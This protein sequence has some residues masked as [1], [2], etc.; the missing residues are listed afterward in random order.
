MDNPSDL[1]RH[2]VQLIE[3]IHAAFVVPVLRLGSVEQVVAAAQPWIDRGSTVLEVP[4]TVP[5][6]GQAVRALRERFGAGV[7][8][9]AG[10]V[11]TLDQL[12]EAA[13]VGCQFAA[14]PAHRPGWVAHC[15][16]LGLLPI[17][18]ALTP[19]EIVAV[20]EAGAPV[21]KIFPVSALG[22]AG[23]L[24]SLRGPFPGVR[25]MPCGGIR[26]EEAD[27]YRAAGAWAIG[28]GRQAIAG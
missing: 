13:A 27:R 5:Q 25:W 7:V 10:T 20:L 3:Q 16:Q 21:V 6:A 15:R 22:G 12:D 18:G 28:I 11:L 2:E 23:Y 26:G 9:G 4:W 8:L 1:P 19:T 24:E 17:P 14:S